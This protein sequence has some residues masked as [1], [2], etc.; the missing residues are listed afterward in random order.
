M[1]QYLQDIREGSSAII[2]TAGCFIALNGTTVAA[3]IVSR[4]LFHVNYGPEDLFLILGYIS[5]V[6]MSVLEMVGG[7]FCLLWPEE[8]QD[9][10]MHSRHL[11]QTSNLTGRCSL[12]SP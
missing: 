6:A 4:W 1:S 3:R 9:N 2:G 10:D 5:F 7:L 12:H 8:L 11:R